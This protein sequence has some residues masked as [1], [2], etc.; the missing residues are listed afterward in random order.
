MSLL[1]DSLERHLRELQ[2]PAP[3]MPKPKPKVTYT[4]FVESASLSYC[5]GTSDKVYHIQL[6]EIQKDESLG[7]SEIYVVNFQYGRRAKVMTTGTKT[8]SPA[9]ISAAKHIFHKL[10]AEKI[11]KGY[12]RY[13]ETDL[14]F[15]YPRVP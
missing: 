11:A 14:P 9:T 7:P 12:T 3:P 5:Q 6:V 13:H 15:R 10:L 4:R 1:G 8:P 2:H